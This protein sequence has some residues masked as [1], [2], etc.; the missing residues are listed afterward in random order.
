LTTSVIRFAVS[1]LQTDIQA[2]ANGTASSETIT[3]YSN[4][5]LNYI[6]NDQ[7]IDAGEIAPTIVA[8]AD[9]V[10]TSEDTAVTI[11]V[12]ANDS[13]LSS[14]PVTLSVGSPNNGTTALAESAPQQITYTPVSD[15]NGTDSFSYT[16]TQGAKTSS[17]SVSVTVQA[18]N[19]NPSINVASTLSI[20][21]G[22]TSIATISI[23]DVDGDELTLTI[24]GTDANSFSLSSDNVLS[25]KQAANYNEKNTYS[26]ILNL[27]DG[28]NTVSKTITVLVTKK[29]EYV[30]NGKTI[31][32]YIQGATVFLDQNYN[33][34]FDTGEL[35]SITK[36]DGSFEISTNDLDLYNCV[37]SRP[38]VAEVPVGAIDSTLGEVTK[39]YR[40]VLP[41]ISDTG[42]SAIVISPFT[43]LLGDAVVQAKSSSSIKDELT[44]AEGCSDV[45][46]S[47][48]S[49][50]T[51]ELN[52]IKNT[53]TSSLNI[54]Y[55]DLVIDFIADTSNSTITE[56]S[57]QNIAKFFPY[58]KQLTDE[59]DSE[60]STIHSK[61]INTDVSI[62][63]DS[64]NAILAD[65]AIAEIPVSFSAIYKTEPNDQGWFIQEKITAFGA[66][67]NNTGEM[68]HYT[69]FG[70]SDNC[71]TSDISLVSLRDASQRYTRTSSFINNN[72]NPSTYNYQLVVEDEQRVDF[73]FDGNPSIEFVSYKTGYI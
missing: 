53:L 73:D 69:C 13:Y 5:I 22:E 28:I 66:K 2:I 8:V 33:F 42:N 70:D 48:A 63:K 3:S 45:G 49:S 46:N 52:Q 32:G 41:S 67:L 11:N 12:L 16:I 55:D 68:N 10:T 43:S 30:F 40:M 35:S 15:F 39:A 18:T 50:I 58:F 20:L 4:D 34:R 60:L 72:Y 57:A 51:S 26:I 65:S 25:L 1:T 9:S 21:E 29:G 62:K 54:S 36:A 14:S 17:A 61:T 44:L 7:N 56:T 24:S 71:T 6:A 59:F 31:D 23:A 37:K 64:I 19:D 47:I 38:I 27:T